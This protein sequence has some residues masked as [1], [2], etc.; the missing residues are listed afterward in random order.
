MADAGDLKSLAWYQACG[1]DSRLRHPRVPGLGAG[2]SFP[3]L[4]AA[5]LYRNLTEGCPR[6]D[7]GI[8]ETW[9][10]FLRVRPK[11][12]ASSHRK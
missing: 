5:N 12:V 3:C 6:G 11:V 8:R 4:P 10:P 9:Y 7:T 1:F 2:A